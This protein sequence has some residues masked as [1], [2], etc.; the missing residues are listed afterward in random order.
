M[1]SQASR[2]TP[3]RVVV[4]GAGLAGLSAADE[5]LRGGHEPIV[6]EARERVGGRVHSRTLEV[7]D[8][9]AVVEMGAEFIL[10]G[11]T[12][13]LGLVERFGL[14]LWDKGMRYG[15]REPRGVEVSPGSLEEAAMLIDEALREGREGTARELLDDLPL[16]PGAREAILARAEVSAAAPA[17]QVPAV[18]LGGLARLSDEPAPSVAGGN[19]RLAEALAAELGER[20]HLGEPVRTVGWSE[21][22]VRVRTDAGE[23]DA[24]AC[25]VAVPA[26]VLGV[27][28]GTGDAGGIEFDPPLPRDLAEALAGIEYGHAAKLFVPLRSRVGLSPSATLAVPER[29]WAWTSTGADGEVQPVLNCFAGSAPALAH[30]GVE[31]GPEKWAERLPALRPDLDLD[32]DAAVLS[33]WDDE[34]WTRAAYSL[35]PSSATIERIVEGTGAITFAGEHVAPEMGA[36]MEGAIRSGRAAAARV[37]GLL[38][39]RA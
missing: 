22:G 36:L 27:N 30:L 35:A 3:S 6:L 11:C 18:E 21:S 23:A 10:P 20:V 4:I 5:L 26:T 39:G 31:A 7:G 37:A 19:G 2:S 28:G 12:E 1:A 13:V 14:G 17:D 15:N 33:T 29:F 38:G 32:V 8:G 16:D 34:E 25:V 9:D 24:D